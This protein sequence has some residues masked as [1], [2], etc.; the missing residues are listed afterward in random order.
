MWCI[1]DREPNGCSS[2]LV[3]LL[4]TVRLVSIVHVRAV[5]CAA[6]RPIDNAAAAA[7]AQ[8]YSRFP[9]SIYATISFSTGLSYPCSR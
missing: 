1:M 3:G 5:R 4:S 8:N 2:P 7:A 9:P 6:E